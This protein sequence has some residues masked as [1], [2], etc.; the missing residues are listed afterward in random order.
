MTLNF[1]LRGHG[2]CRW[3]GS[4]SSI[5]TPTLKFLGLTVRKTW[6]ILCVCVIRSVTLT[7][8][9]LSLKLVCESHL[10]WGI[11]LPN[12]GTLGLWVLEFFAMYATDGRTKKQRLLLPSVRSGHYNWVDWKLPAH[13]T[14]TA[15]TCMYGHSKSEYNEGSVTSRPTA[16]AYSIVSCGTYHMLLTVYT[17][18]NASKRVGY[19]YHSTAIIAT[20]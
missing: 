8:D 16:H 5:H 1:N 11:F 13:H 17:V 15:G 20:H 6:H 18:I 2:A 19:I 4:M 7:F 3:C 14:E 10:R 12:L 9:L